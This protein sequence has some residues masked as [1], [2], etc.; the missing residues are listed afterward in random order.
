[1]A[2]FICGLGSKCK[3]ACMGTPLDG[4][5]PCAAPRGHARPINGLFFLAACVLSCHVVVIPPRAMATTPRQPAELIDAVVKNELADRAQQHRWMYAIEKSQGDQTLAMERVET[6]YGPLDR[7]IAINGAPLNASQRQKE[8]IRI[9]RLLRDPSPLLKLKREHD[10]DELKL[11][12]LMKLMSAAYIYE[13][14]GTENNLLRVN[15]RPNPN[16]DPPNYEARVVHGLGGTILVD[17]EKV[18]LVELSA[19]LASP[20]QFGYGLLGRVD[21]GTV[22]IKR[23]EVRQLEW[24]TSM[25][26][27]QIVGHLF[28]LKALNKQQHET[29]SN[30][31]AVPDDLSLPEANKLLVANILREESPG[32]PK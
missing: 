20:V 17:A 2:Q 6:Q 9:T 14:A 7:L 18:R 11:E 29:R 22:E 5:Q 4:T 3:T 13:Y 27:V 24:K 30:F 1:M 21:S 23:V 10:E 26:N 15:F 31:Q 19:Q 28:L 32:R 16:Y 8:D 25:I 12:K